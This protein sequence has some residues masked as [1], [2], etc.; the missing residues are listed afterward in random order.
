MTSS[1]PA[2]SKLL[3]NEGALSREKSRTSSRGF[4]IAIRVTV[5]LLA[6]GAFSSLNAQTI[7]TFNGAGPSWDTTSNWTTSPPIS[8]SPGQADAG[9]ANS[10][11]ARIAMGITNSSLIGINLSSGTPK[12]Q[13]L[14]SI[15]ITVGTGSAGIRLENNSGGQ[16]GVLTLNGNSGNFISNASLGNFVL[17]KTGSGGRDVTLELKNTGAFATTN[18][19]GIV[20]NADMTGTGN[21]A[22]TGTSGTG[23]ISSTNYGTVSGTYNGAVVLTGLTS[24]TGSTTVTTGYLSLGSL[25]A[26]GD[27]SSVTVSST[28][29]TS[30]GQL[31]LGVAAGGTY[32]LGPGNLTLNG[33]GTGTSGSTT[34]ALIIGANVN[35]SSI[36]TVSNSV[37]LNSSSTIDTSGVAGTGTQEVLAITG[38]ISGASGAHLT[39]SGDGILRLTGANTYQGETTITAGTLELAGNSGALAGTSKITVNDGG[40]LLLSGTTAN[41]KINDTPPAVVLGA[42]PVN[43]TSDA[44]IQ[45]TDTAVVNETVG[46]LTLSSSST[47]DY[48]DLAAGNTLRFANSSGETWTGTL[49]VYD[50]SFFTDH[51]FF[52]SSYSGLTSAQLSQIKLYSDDG[53]TDLG[54]LQITGS[55]EIRP[56][57]EPSSV[58]AGLSLLSLA[59]YRERRWFFRCRE[60]RVKKA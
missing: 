17:L 35:G 4:A 40:T 55:G 23:V 20:I 6:L 52:G 29:P 5:L 3:T 50:W 28:S 12:G 11:I 32:D 46:T 16:S 58:F 41:S 53:S 7:Y 31:Q 10:D 27:T 48:G 25:S 13:S 49:S 30:G 44:A 26:L 8:D 42:G 1:T 43:N 39:K 2:P 9:V 47:I 56:V 36:H 34:G 60:A 45:M 19:G 57:P 18:T 33:T 15:E 59:A 22:I 24:H 38:I 14:G 21:L 51:L 54:A 37:V